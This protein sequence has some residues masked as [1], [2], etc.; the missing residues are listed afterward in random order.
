MTSPA[1]ARPRPRFAVAARVCAAL[2]ATAATLAF[3]YLLL[4]Q[5]PYAGTPES[6]RP[7][8]IVGHQPAR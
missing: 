7:G 3:S 2:T 5:P 4:H 6:P 1:A 8:I